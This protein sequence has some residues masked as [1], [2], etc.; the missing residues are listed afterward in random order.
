LTEVREGD[1]T[2]GGFGCRL[3]LPQLEILEGRIG[4]E[5]VEEV[6]EGQLLGNV[7]DGK[8]FQTSEVVRRPVR[9]SAQPD[10]A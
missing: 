6:V 2:R 3:R 8:P 4:F 7:L 9:Y 10:G 5:K 1:M